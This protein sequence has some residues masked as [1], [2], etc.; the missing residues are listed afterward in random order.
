M[1]YVAL[2]PLLGVGVENMTGWTS[3]DLGTVALVI[4][5]GVLAGIVKETLQAYRDNRVW[6]GWDLR[7]L[8][9]RPPKD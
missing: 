3:E 9:R 1:P 4:I 2:A 7:R 5:A 6:F 8:R